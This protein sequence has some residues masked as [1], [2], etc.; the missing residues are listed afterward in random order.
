MQH[1]HISDVNGK[2][3][4]CFDTGLDS[5]S[6]ARTK[7]SQ[8]LTEAGYLVHSDGSHEQW[9]AA[10]VDEVNG[11]MRVHGPLSNGKRLDLILDEIETQPDA[12]LQAVVSW[13]RAK[14]FLG[15][16]Q[17][18]LNPGAAFI[19]DGDSPKQVFI[20]PEFLSSRC[21]LTEGK[22]FDRYNCPDLSGMD[23]ATFCAGVMLYQ[24]FSKVHPYPSKDIFQDMR[25]NVFLPI[26]FAVPDLNKKLAGLIQAAL[27]LP[28]AQAASTRHFQST[29]NSINIL[30]ELLETLTDSSKNIVSISSLI[31]TLPEEEK[32]STEK[33]KQK[34]LFR[35]NTI[36]KARRFVARHKIA[37]LCSVGGFIVLFFLVVSTIQNISERPTTEGMASDTVIMA[38]YDAFSSLDHIFMEAIVQGANKADINAAA[39]YF[40]IVKTRQAYEMSDASLLIPAEEWRRDGGEL[41]APDVF[42]VTDLTITYLSGDESDLMMYRTEYQLWAPDLDHSIRRTDVITLKR[43]NRRNWRITEIIRTEH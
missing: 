37:L 21:L 18:A 11:G 34:Y 12:A 16:E 2:S 25:E 5:R 43:D 39:S 22:D 8:S 14:M 27:S 6:F 13:I 3:A 29:S 24:I 35:Q 4:V 38:Y 36:V 30:T 40:A 32:A 17:S 15:E 23:A 33:E 28:N 7:M 10:G 26:H 41:P 31:E 19:L 42:G 9:K 20:S 1:I